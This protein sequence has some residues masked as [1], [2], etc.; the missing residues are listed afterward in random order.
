[1][2]TSITLQV[3]EAGSDED[4]QQPEFPLVTGKYWKVKRFGG[5]GVR[6]HLE[7]V[8]QARGDARNRSVSNLDPSTIPAE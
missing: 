7:M 2:L 8:R 4:E 6:D 5:V 3:E 1:M